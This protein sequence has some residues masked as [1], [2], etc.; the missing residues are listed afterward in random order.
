MPEPK[1]ETVQK[2]RLK[3]QMLREHGVR[4]E[5]KFTVQEAAPEKG[6]SNQ[7]AEAGVSAVSRSPEKATEQAAP[8]NAEQRQTRQRERLHFSE[9]ERSAEPVA[10][11]PIS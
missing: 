8:S 11:E 3:R 2:K 7:T 10:A 4:P 9:E 6:T 1:Q 5:L